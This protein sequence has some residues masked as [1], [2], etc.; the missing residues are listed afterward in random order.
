MCP[1]HHDRAPQSQPAP[2]DTKNSSESP[3]TRPCCAAWQPPSAPRLQRSR[4]A[5]EL[6]VGRGSGRYALLGG[7]R[8]ACPPTPTLCSPPHPC[9]CAGM[10]Q[11]GPLGGRAQQQR[12]HRECAL[13]APPPLP[14]RRRWKPLVAWGEAACAQWAPPAPHTRSAGGPRGLRAHPACHPGLQPGPLQRQP[15]RAAD[16]RL[17]GH[18][19]RVQAVS[20]RCGRA[21]AAA[22]GLGAGS[23]H[24]PWHDPIGGT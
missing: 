11:A 14:F 13:P 19:E 21:A 12:R 24:V 6:Q 17:A 5:A 9:S 7:D 10:P 23:R 2:P 18:A 15:L 4:P 8:P 16:G 20:G 1:H 3:V 22:E